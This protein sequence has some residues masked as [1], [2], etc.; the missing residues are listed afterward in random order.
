MSDSRLRDLERDVARDGSPSARLALANELTRLGRGEDAYEV[1]MPARSDA[2]VRRLLARTPCWTHKAGDAGRTRSLDVRPVTRPHV[3]WRRQVFSDPGIEERSFRNEPHLLSSP[4]G[5]V[6]GESGT[7]NVHGLDPET[8]EPVWTAPID[9]PM[10][11]GEHV[12]GGQVPSVHELASGRLVRANLRPARF[13]LGEGLAV[14]VRSQRYKN[15]LVGARWNGPTSTLE[16]DWEV[17]LG[18]QA[19]ILITKQHVLTRIV[20]P[21]LVLTHGGQ[22]A[23]ELED[24]T[25]VSAADARGLLGRNGTDLR[26]VSFDGQGWRQGRFEPLAL[27]GSLVLALALVDD[28]VELVVLDRRDGAERARLRERIA[29]ALVRGQIHATGGGLLSAYSPDGVLLWSIP[30]EDLFEGER[31]QIVAV[32]ALPGRLYALSFGGVVACIGESA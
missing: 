29:I 9:H 16:P 8:G 30:E 27:S 31:R 32:A 28:T 19:D 12:V 26:M 18:R 7:S 4:L 23:L 25:S 24:G 22:P 1:L 2:E 10:L 14:W 13:H 5:I 20:D 3:R 17:V 15:F 6:V 21:A 11:A